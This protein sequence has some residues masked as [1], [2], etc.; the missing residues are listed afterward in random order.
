MRER[1]S[2]T[3]YDGVWCW[4]IGQGII[5]YLFFSP[6]SRQGKWGVKGRDSEM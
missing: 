4:Q 3:G 5:I 6:I 1:W 2:F